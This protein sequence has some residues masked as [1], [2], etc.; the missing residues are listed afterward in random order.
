MNVQCTGGSRGLAKEMRALKMRSIVV[1]RWKLTVTKLRAIIKGDPLTQEVAKEL[2]INHSMVIL[3]LK[4]TGR[5]R[6]SVSG[7]LMN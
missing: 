6:N 1:D 2:N 3:H 7:C 4:Q 5:M